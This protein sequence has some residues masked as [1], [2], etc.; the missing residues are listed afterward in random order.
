[1]RWR[2]HWWG[3][4]ILAETEDDEALLEQ[5]MFR[6]PGRAFKA[7]GSG[8]LL[9]ETEDGKLKLVFVE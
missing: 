2:A 8:E 5:L 4:E 9:R 1:M 7:Y 3:T 6:L